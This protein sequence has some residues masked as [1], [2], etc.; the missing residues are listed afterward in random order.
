VGFWATRLVR[1]GNGFS[2]SVDPPL[3]LTHDPVIT[4]SNGT[5]WTLVIRKV[6]G[7]FGPIH[8]EA[9]AFVAHQ[10]GGDG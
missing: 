1:T 4:D 5:R 7:G 8:I 9:Q 10:R 2:E 3:V 6:E